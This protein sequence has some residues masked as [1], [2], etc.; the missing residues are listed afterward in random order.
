MTIVATPPNVDADPKMDSSSID[1]D[2]DDH[3]DSNSDS[4]SSSSSSSIDSIASSGS[5]S[6]CGSRSN[7]R[8]DLDCWRGDTIGMRT[9]DNPDAAAIATAHVV[10]T[11]AHH[12]HPQDDDDEEKELNSV[13]QKIFKCVARNPW[14]FLVTSILITV[15]LSAVGVII[16]EFAVEVESRGK[17][18]YTVDALQRSNA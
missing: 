8:D 3:S 5:D 7:E 17:R 10:T 14:I 6:D 12:D 4:S 18:N 16:G 15:A 2:D 13:L 9:D 1:D 11:D